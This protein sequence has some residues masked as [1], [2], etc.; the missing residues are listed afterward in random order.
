MIKITNKL[1]LLLFSLLLVSFISCDINNNSE[2]DSN[3]QTVNESHVTQIIRTLDIFNNNHYADHK[4]ESDL[5]YPN[6]TVTQ[7]NSGNSGDF[8]KI[9]IP[10]AIDPKKVIVLYHKTGQSTKIA[11][12]YWD[13]NDFSLSIDDSN[14]ESN[15]DYFEHK[16][17]EIN[18]TFHRGYPADSSVTVSSD[19]D[20]DLEIEVHGTTY[21]IIFSYTISPSP[22]TASLTIDGMN[23]SEELREFLHTRYPS[24]SD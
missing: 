23:Y 15:F 6:H 18:G 9:T 19:A 3:E 11:L 4:F 14:G 10:G 17:I 1:V 20:D 2:N 7:L 21:D 12:R 24:D 5:N 22:P 8:Y 13:V 16:I